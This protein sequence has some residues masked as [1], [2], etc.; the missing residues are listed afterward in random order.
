MYTTT[1]SYCG[2]GCGLNL[3]VV[4][5]KAA[6]VAP[7]NRSPVGS[8]K[9]CTRG[10]HAAKTLSE[11]RIEKPSVKGEPVTWDE[12][13]EEMEERAQLNSA[14]GSDMIFENVFKE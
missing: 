8:G 12:I 10:L 13:A 7:Y 2:T 4:N 14:T 9:L 3:I 1:C 11:W 6:G 5:G